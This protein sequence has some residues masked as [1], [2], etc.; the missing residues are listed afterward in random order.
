MLPAGA[1]TSVFVVNEEN[2]SSDFFLRSIALLVSTYFFI[3]GHINGPSYDFIKVI[4]SYNTLFPFLVLASV[5]LE[6]QWR[7]V[8]INRHF[9]MELLFRKLSSIVRYFTSSTVDNRWFN[10]LQFR[11]LCKE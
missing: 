7:A 6:Y 11:I 8:L 4:C 10:M 3:A 2:A 9:L 1:V 5:I